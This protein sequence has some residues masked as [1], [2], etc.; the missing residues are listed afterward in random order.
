VSGPSTL[1]GLGVGWVCVVV[2]VG[3]IWCW[4]FFFFGVGCGVEASCFVC[5]TLGGFFGCDRWFW[6]SVRGVGGYFG[7]GF[8]GF[9]L[10]WVLG[11][12]FLE[13]FQDEEEGFSKP[14]TWWRK[15]IQRRYLLRDGYRDW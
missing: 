3:F 9:A 12:P 13:F 10:F 14:C 6:V 5:G 15:Y 2:L 8:G 11:F 4:F 1:S 7:F